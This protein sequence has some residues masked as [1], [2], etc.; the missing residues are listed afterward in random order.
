MRN[1]FRNWLD[2]G[3]GGEWYEQPYVTNRDVLWIS[4]WTLIICGIIIL[5]CYLNNL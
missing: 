5:R 4:L 2:K 3:Y 1:K